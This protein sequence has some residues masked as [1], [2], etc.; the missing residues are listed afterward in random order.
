M[1]RTNAMVIIFL[2]DD[3]KKDK[4]AKLFKPKAPSYRV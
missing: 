2:V 3:I 1:N 4:L